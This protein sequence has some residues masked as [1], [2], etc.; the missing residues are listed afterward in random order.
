MGT[1][2]YYLNNFSNVNVF[3]IIIFAI[4]VYLVALFGLNIFSSE[5][6]AIL[7]KFIKIRG[8]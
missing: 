6:K 8:A 2:V 5:E 3:L 4:I 1:P 7:R